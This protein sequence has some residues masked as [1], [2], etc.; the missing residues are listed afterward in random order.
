MD[1]VMKNRTRPLLPLLLSALCLGFAYAQT[2]TDDAPAA[3][4]DY[5]HLIGP[6]TPKQLAEN[7]AYKKAH[8]GA[9][10]PVDAAAVAGLNGYASAAAAGVNGLDGALR[11]AMAKNCPD[12]GEKSCSDLTGRVSSEVQLPDGVTDIRSAGKETI[13]MNDPLLHD[14]P[15][16]VPCPKNTSC[17]QA[18]QLQQSLKDQQSL[19]AA[20]SNATERGLAGSKNDGGKPSGQPLL[21]LAES[22]D[23]ASPGFITN[24][25][26]KTSVRGEDSHEASASAGSA[27][28][29][30]ASGTQIDGEPPYQAPGA[31][32]GRI[33]DVAASMDR[34]FAANGALS[35]AD[36]SRGGSAGALVPAPG[37][38][39][40]NAGAPNVNG[41]TFDSLRRDVNGSTQGGAI[42]ALMDSDNK[43]GQ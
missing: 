6:L 31:L 13:L 32:A 12:L 36:S 7:E 1:A 11:A 42:K 39:G 23:N 14:P 17:A 35:A 37:Q 40:S 34:S 29:P 8:S 3:P 25:A 30:A 21:A 19:I 27:A 4:L 26:S 18:L 5:N 10:A 38:G 16:Q 20:A 2:K 43:N 15:L 9:P 41:A 22:A 24:A 33:L 28:A